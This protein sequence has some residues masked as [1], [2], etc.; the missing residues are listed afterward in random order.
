MGHFNDSNIIVNASLRMQ[1][2]IFKRIRTQVIKRR[3]K[4]YQFIIL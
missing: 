4:L 3:P 2:I 1:T